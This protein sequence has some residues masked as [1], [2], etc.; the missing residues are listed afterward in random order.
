MKK[1]LVAVFVLLTISFMT[2]F[3]YDKMSAPKVAYI[4][5]QEVFNGFELKKDY[6][7]KLNATKT[8]RQRIID[9]LETTLKILGKK[10]EDDQGK[11][12]DDVRLFEVR[13]EDYFNKKKLF[14]GDNDLQ[15]KKYDDEIIA[16]LNQYIK[17]FGKEKGY[18][19]IF[20]NDGN[21]SLMYA[22][23]NN[24]ITKEIIEYVNERYRG[25]R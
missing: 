19:Y 3:V 4:V 2:W 20:G 25:V 18:T 16:Q 11:N 5:I 6:E 1:V 14:D 7:K 17:D 9:S 8:S 24:N 15:T 21:G 23:E 12:K 22:K 10:I 13:R